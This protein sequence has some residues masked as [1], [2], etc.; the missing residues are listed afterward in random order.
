MTYKPVTPKTPNPTTLRP[1]TDPPV[2]ATFN[3][4][5]K[6]YCAAL[7]V[8]LFAFVAT[9]MPKNP[10]KPEAKA[11]TKNDI[12]TN[13][14]SPLLFAANANRQATITTKIAST[15]YSAFKNAM[16]PSAILAP[17]CFILSVPSSWLLIQPVFQNA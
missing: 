4:F 12:D 17:I 3:A 7:V 16:A 2:K 14:E 1:I 8:R 10:A 13:Q 11:P 9:F 5:A 15:R 6:L